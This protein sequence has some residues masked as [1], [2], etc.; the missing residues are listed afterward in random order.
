MSLFPADDCET[1]RHILHI[2]GYVQFHI[3]YYS[4]ALENQQRAYECHQKVDDFN[5]VVWAGLDIGA[6]NLQ[7][8]RLEEGEQAIT[9]HLH[10]A[11]QM[12]ACSAEAYGL[13][14][15]GHLKL[16]QG[17]DVA[18]I[19]LFRQSLS[20]Q[21]GLRTE[22]GRVAA[23]LG[24]GFAYLHLGDFAKARKWLKTAVEAAR[25]IEHRRRL[26][27]ALLGLGLTEIAAHRFGEAKLC[28]TEA[29]EIAQEC[30]SL[31][32]LAAGFAAL[33]RLHRREG[34][35]KRLSTMPMRRC[36]SLKS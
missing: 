30:Q 6:S 11:Q 35:L 28:L 1:R 17:N 18:A 33:A 12:G 9:E 34:E 13:N 15:L 25:R 24:I 31:G 19:D 7:L 20:R 10:L 36:N 14:Q 27:E 5:G 32:N 21:E 16:K 2:L 26:V 29:V 8:G 3:G 23:Q 22:H 4:L